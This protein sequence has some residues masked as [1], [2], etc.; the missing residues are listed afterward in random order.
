[1]SSSQ[2]RQSLAEKKPARG[3]YN[4]LCGAFLDLVLEARANAMVEEFMPLLTTSMR[5]SDEIN[6][7]TAVKVMKTRSPIRRNSH[8]DGK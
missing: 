2:S 4:R 3:R 8:P 6:I 7:A 5:R 1:M